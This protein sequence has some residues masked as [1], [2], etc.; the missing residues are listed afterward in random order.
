M[1][2]ALKH[3]GLGSHVEKRFYTLGERRTKK[4]KK[5]NGPVENRSVKNSVSFAAELFLGGGCRNVGVLFVETL[6]ATRGIDQFL[7]A[8]EKG[9]AAGTDFNPQ[10]VAFDG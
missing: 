5:K 3:A 6:D 4:G 7:L 1:G 8:S 2:C 9:V 10:H